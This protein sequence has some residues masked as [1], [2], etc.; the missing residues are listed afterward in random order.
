MWKSS[1]IVSLFC[2]S[3]T[4]CLFTEISPAAADQVAPKTP[5]GQMMSNLNPANWKL[6]SLQRMMPQ[7]QE[8]ARL[9]K[10]KDGLVSEV[11]KTASNSWNRTKDA[12]NPQRFFTASARTPANTAPEEKKPGFFQ[13]LFSPSIPKDENATMSSFLKQDRPTP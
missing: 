8:K 4:I 12:L 13:S 2:L 3:L 1:R 6:P 10:K 5:F 11:G 9:K 7:A